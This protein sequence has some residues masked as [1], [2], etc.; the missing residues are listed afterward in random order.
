[1]SN[2]NNSFTLTPRLTGQI[3]RP[4]QATQFTIGD[5]VANSLT[6]NLVTPM[7]FALP[8][9][10]GRLYG[11]RMTIT[12]ASGNLVITAC[13]LDLLL[14]RPEADIPFAAAGYPKDNDPLTLTAAM[15]KE[16]IAVI[17]FTAAAWRNP[18]GGLT[19]ST[20]GW[21]AAKLASS[22]AFAPLNTGSLGAGIVGVVQAA[23]VWNPGNVVNT[24]DVTLDVDLD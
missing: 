7:S 3:V 1:M 12:P 23:D 20:V 14:F 4:A 9:G 10:D 18:L 22:R 17:S 16:L 6:A 13:A 11:A 8:R 24:I 2:P 15:Y 19:A 21:Q 5:H